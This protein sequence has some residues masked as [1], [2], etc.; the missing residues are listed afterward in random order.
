MT[1]LLIRLYALPDPA[2][3][4]GKIARQGTIIRRARA[5]EKFRVIGNVLRR[6]LR[7]EELERVKEKIKA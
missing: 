7:D 2:P 1:D 5:D 3:G 6:V 4:L